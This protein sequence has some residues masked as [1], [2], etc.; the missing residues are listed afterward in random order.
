EPFYRSPEA[1]QAG[2]Q[3]TGLGLYVVK[4]IADAHGCSVEVESEEGKGTTVTV[5]LPGK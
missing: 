2:I 3:G 4:M 5:R 1:M